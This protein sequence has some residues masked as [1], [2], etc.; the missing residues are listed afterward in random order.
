ML[1]AAA[2][3]VPVRMWQGVSPVPVRMWQGVSPSLGA[4]VAADRRCLVLRY[5]ASCVAYWMLKHAYS[6]HM[7]YSGYS[8]RVLRVLTQAVRRSWLPIEAKA[9]KQRHCRDCVEVSTQSTP[10]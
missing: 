7:G 9:K 8:H 6:A 3:T 10:A 4:D 2:Q 1:R 5:I